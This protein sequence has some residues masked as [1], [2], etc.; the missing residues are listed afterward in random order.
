[1]IV[2]MALVAMRGA[3]A[4]AMIVMTWWPSGTAGSVVQSLVFTSFAVL[5]GR[6]LFAATERVGKVDAAAHLA[7][8][9]AMVWML[10]SMPLLMGTMAA[11][12]GSGHHHDGAAMDHS[13]DMSSMT[14]P[15]W[16]TAVTVVVIAVMLA[17]AGWWLS[18]LVRAP[19]QRRHALCHLGM[20]V[21]MAVMLAVMH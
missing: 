6:D 3:M 20:S 14:T 13:M 18:R 12:G 5:C 11:G 16:A 2:G 7:M 10:L 8:N 21:G 15:G 1:M 4:V 19:D 9:A 17:S